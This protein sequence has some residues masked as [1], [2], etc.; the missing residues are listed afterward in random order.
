MIVS[1]KADINTGMPRQRL[2]HVM[3]QEVGVERK[4]IDVYCGRKGTIYITFAT[5]GMAPYQG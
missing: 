4:T 5:R 3:A 1:V 2:T